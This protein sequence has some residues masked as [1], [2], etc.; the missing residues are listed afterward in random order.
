[1]E[2]EGVEDARLDAGYHADGTVSLPMGSGRAAGLANPLHRS[3]R[4]I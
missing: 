2:G 1:M 3:R 4:E